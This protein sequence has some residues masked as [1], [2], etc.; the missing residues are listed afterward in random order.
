VKAEHGHYIYLARSIVDPLP[1]PVLPA[2]F[3]LRGMAGEEDIEQRA[4]VHRNA[5]LPSRMTADAYRAFMSA[6]GYLADLDSVVVAPDG[7]FAAFAMAWLDPRNRIGE[8]EPVG[9]RSLFRRMGLGKAVL[10]R[11]M[12]Q[13]RLHGMEQAIVYADADNEAAI[14]LYLSLGFEF[15][16]SFC[17]YVK[18]PLW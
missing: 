7:S 10:L 11:G 9:T 4:E 13:M 18:Q 8:F 5:F 3:T 15:K 2:G 12:R 17:D 16:T 1:G 14:R 6:P